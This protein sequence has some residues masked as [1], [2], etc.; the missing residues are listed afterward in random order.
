MSQT[1][2]PQLPLFVKHNWSYFGAL[3]LTYIVLLT[4]KPK[5]FSDLHSSKLFV[6]QQAPGHCVKYIICCHNHCYNRVK[7]LK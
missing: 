4:G 1:E 7:L 2:F 3:G 6:F 5:S